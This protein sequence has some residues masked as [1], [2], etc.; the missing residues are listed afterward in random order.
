MF[1]FLNKSSKKDDPNFF[2]QVPIKE[3]SFISKLETVPTLTPLAE[4]S[5][6]LLTENEYNH[7]LFP[8]KEFDSIGSEIRRLRNFEKLTAQKDVEIEKL[9]AEIQSWEKKY[10]EEIL[11]KDTKISELL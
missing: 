9:K 5:I 10:N 4:K 1:K 6:E 3:S 7:V 8:K 2:A 11:T